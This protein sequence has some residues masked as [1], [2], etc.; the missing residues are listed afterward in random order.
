MTLPLIGIPA[1]VKLI[2]GYPFHAV[3]EKYINAVAHG[4][5][6]LPVLIPALGEGRELQALRE[7]TEIEDLIERLDGLF[8]SGSPSNLE[9]HHYGKAGDAGPYDPQR[10]ATTLPLIRTALTA[11][12]PVLAVCRGFQELNVALGGSLHARVHEIPE[13][14]DH[15]E[16]KTLAR[17]QQYEPVHPVRLTKNGVL[18]SLVKTDEVMVNSLHGQGLDRLAD[19]LQIEATAPDGLVEAVSVKYAKSFA[20]G[21][22]WHPEWEFRNNPLSQALFAAFGAAARERAL[23]RARQAVR[24][25]VQAAA[26]A[27]SYS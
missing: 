25:A 1:D 21:V 9:P 24:Q 23:Q 22:Q 18:A 15:R 4:S 12:L 27:R 14:L 20:I 26:S 19:D 3:G 6:A 10:D 16:D 11:G 8:L 17:A 5:Q 13:M 7:H 2:D